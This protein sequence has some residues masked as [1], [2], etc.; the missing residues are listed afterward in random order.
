MH[1]ESKKAWRVMAPAENNP[2]TSVP[3]NGLKKVSHDQDVTQEA[4]HDG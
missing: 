3:T 4:S 2:A 1:E